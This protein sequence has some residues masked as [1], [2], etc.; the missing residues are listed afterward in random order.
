MIYYF[1]NFNFIKM[2]P[3]VQASYDNALLEASE[4]EL[5]DV[6]LYLI[7]QG[8]NDELIKD[9][10]IRRKLG[11]SKWNKKPNHFIF[12]LSNKCSISGEALNENVKQLGCSSCRNV[13]KYDALNHWLNIKY[14][15]PLC[16]SS[17]E[18]Y[19]VYE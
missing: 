10:K 17:N 2:H 8:A 19:L 12:K 11:L 1:Y 6:V 13:F 14:E 18:F 15:C 5:F 9:F 3:D 4:N 7:E 16:K